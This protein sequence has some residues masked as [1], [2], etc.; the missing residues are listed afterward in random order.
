MMKRNI[1]YK[2]L[3]IYLK[4]EREEEIEKYYWLMCIINSIKEIIFIIFISK[5]HTET[6]YKIMNNV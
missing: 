5:Q 1:R 6:E 2:E 3:S 4:S